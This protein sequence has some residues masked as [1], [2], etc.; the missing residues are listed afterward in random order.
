MG[1]TNFCMLINKLHEPNQEPPSVP[2]R[3]DSI[4]YDVQSLLH[5]DLNT[6]LETDESKLFREMCH[7]VSG[8]NVP[9]EGEHKLFHMAEALHPDQCRHPLVVSEDPDVFVLSHIRL[10]RYDTIQIDRYGKYY[11]VTRLARECLPYPIGN[12]FFFI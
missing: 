11:P 3:F 7:V 2:K 9:G 6:A 8:C 12:L 5:V 10:D 4:L 1:I